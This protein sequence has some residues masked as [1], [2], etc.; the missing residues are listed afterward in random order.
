MKRALAAAGTVAVAVAALLC[1]HLALAADAK[2]R[3]A[4]VPPGRTYSA[5]VLVAGHGGHF[6]LAEVVVDPSDAENPIQ[7][8]SLD[9]V[10]IG[11]TESHKTHDARL[12]PDG[13]TL[14]W[15]TYALD[16]EGKLHVGKS[17]VRT[18]KVLKD[19]ALTPDP[20]A[21]AKTGPAYCA[22]GQT[23]T[24]FLP[25]FMGS[26]GYVDVFDKK[27]LALRHRVF[28]SDLGYKAGSYQFVHG[29]NS[30]DMKKFLLTV[31]LK[32]EDG[33]MTGR[34]DLVMLDLAA[35]EKGKLR[36]LARNT[37][38]GEPGKTITF[39]QYFSM[40]D[41]VVFQSA[42]DRMWVVDAATLKLVDEKM[43]KQVGENHDI[44]PTPDGK[45]ALL[46]LRTT[47]TP[48]CDEKGNPIPD[49]VTA[50]HKKITDGALML[51]D[52]TARALVGKPASVCFGCHKDAG[53]G[54]KNAVL[55]GL[56]ARFAK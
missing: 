13:T 49:P 6:A 53:K 17:D 26:E 3:A 22:S 48:G 11:T 55:C 15:S 9:Q 14:F 18:G 39:R 41:K 20:R 32:G 43:T 27:T 36:E 40:D 12:D 52:A 16:K 51:Y 37:L 54:D 50:T 46:T 8:K 1:A 45:F 29:S 31:T 28:I 19:V 56:A 4:G 21:P 44:Q 25:V 38:S 2:P 42:G 34:Q 47:D 5:S 35:L 24:A 30:N 10:N 7:V 23:R 33:K